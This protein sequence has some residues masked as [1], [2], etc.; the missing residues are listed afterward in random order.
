MLRHLLLFCGSIPSAGFA[1]ITQD[2]LEFQ[3]GSSLKG[4]A[5]AQTADGGYLIGGNLCTFAI[6]QY[7][8]L[9]LKV[10]ANGTLAWSRILDVDRETCSSMALT[11]DGGFVLAGSVGATQGA[12]DMALLKLTASGDVEWGRAVGTAGY[13]E[14]ANH[15]L[16][17]PDGGYLLTGVLYDPPPSPSFYHGYLAKL[18]AAGDLEWAT[19][20][21]T[22]FSVAHAAAQAADGGFV[23]ACYGGAAG[24]HIVKLDAQGE[25]VWI[26][27]NET[28]QHGGFHD[29]I[30]TSD[31]NFVLAGTLKADPASDQD[32]CIVKITPDGVLI[33]DAVIPSSPGWDEANSV[34]EVGDG[35]V[36]AGTWD[37]GEIVDIDP[38]QYLNKVDLNG[39]LL[40]SRRIG[41]GWQFSHGI[42][43]TSDGGLVIT[44]NSGVGELALT[45]TDAE[46]MPCIACGVE[47]N[48]VTAHTQ[49][50]LTDS[51]A[52]IAHPVSTSTAVSASATSVG[53]LTSTC[54]STAMEEAPPPDRLCITPQ[55][56]S[57]MAIV[58]IPAAWALSGCQL[59]LRDAT[60]RVVR[61]IEAVDTTVVLD[62]N[63]C[64]PG[65]YTLEVMYMG[66]RFH[67]KLIM[68]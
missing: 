30:P 26:K 8:M 41:N 15:V 29:I 66:Q 6:Q 51:T 54:V 58:R 25:M 47:E 56:M 10:D 63:D 27:Y 59:I 36:V 39:N 68:E 48:N 50:I 16:P 65:S 33:R 14:W 62:R 23:V 34:V 64:V 1:Q 35:Y 9:A 4:H 18:D 7:D 61:T 53:S 38:R 5:V 40:W 28:S 21:G 49:V 43:A 31:G 22:D 17:T 52:T 45:R 55:P 13:T 57:N 46:G 20:L 37:G 44:G 2:C 19:E 60:G 11:P 12:Y 42:D 3:T 67:G 24:A 32:P